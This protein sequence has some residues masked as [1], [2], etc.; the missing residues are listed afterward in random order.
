MYTS[1]RGYILNMKQ[2]TTALMS[3]GIHI[4]IALMFYSIHTNVRTNVIYQTHLHSTSV[5]QHI[6]H[7]HS[8]VFYSIH[9]HSTNVL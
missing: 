2:A 5:L 4:S 8:T 9:I 6:T 1:C 3:Y 7:L